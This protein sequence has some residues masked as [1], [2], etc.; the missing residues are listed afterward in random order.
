MKGGGAETSSAVRCCRCHWNL[1]IT[2]TNFGMPGTHKL[3]LA[4]TLPAHFLN[5]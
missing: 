1:A 3:I 2:A 5:F 4:L